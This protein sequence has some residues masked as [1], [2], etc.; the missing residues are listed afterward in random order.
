MFRYPEFFAG[1]GV[2]LGLTQV[3]TARH[4]KFTR[5][6]GIFEMILAAL[7]VAGTFLMYALGLNQ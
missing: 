5:R 3:A 1:I 4:I 6:L 7:S 2:R